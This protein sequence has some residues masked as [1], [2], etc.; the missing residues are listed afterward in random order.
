MQHPHAAPAS[1]QPFCTAP[2]G[3]TN[4]R[5]MWLCMLPGPAAQQRGPNRQGPQL[6]VCPGWHQVSNQVH[7]CVPC[8][9]LRHAGSHNQR[10]WCSWPQPTQKH[11]LL[12]HRGPA[13]PAGS[14]PVLSR[15]SRSHAC[16]PSAAAGKDSCT[17]CGSSPTAK[18]LP[19]PPTRGQLCC[20]CGQAVRYTATRESPQGSAPAAHG[21]H[22]AAPR[23][24]C[25][26]PP[27]ACRPAA[28]LGVCFIP[29]R[30]LLVM[31]V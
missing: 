29:T 15:H 25:C 8:Y 4:I 5:G 26:A 17:D 11:L 3:C 27:Q 2:Q 30:A 28:N 9:L 1:L 19:W 14:A 16:A 24:G 31:N 6:H 18:Q 13:V 7:A 20:Q 21:M 12:A 22:A 10:C 23:S